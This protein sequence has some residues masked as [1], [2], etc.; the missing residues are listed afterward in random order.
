M[1]MIANIVGWIRGVWVR[2]FGLKTIE[3]V[4]SAEI[5]VSERMQN[6]ID[7]WARMYRNEPPWAKKS[8]KGLNLPAAISGEVARAVTLEMRVDCTGSA[9]AEY[10]TEQLDPVLREIRRIMEYAQAKGG[11]IIKPYVSGD[12]ILTDIIQ[13]D[14]FYPLAF[15]GESISD[16]I[17][18]DRRQIGR[19]FFTRLERHR[20]VA[21]GWEVSNKAFRSESESELGGETSLTAVPDWAELEPIATF[22]NVDFPLFAYFRTPYSN[23]IDPGSP[24]GVS[25]FA[26]AVDLIEDADT[27][28][29]NLLWEFESGKRALYADVLA[30][31]RD[32]N[33][34]PILPEKRL[35]RVLNESKR[36]VSDPVGFQEWTPTLREA[37]ILNGLDAILKRIEFTC[38]LA[39]GTL[40]NPET[41][42]KTAT[43]IA[44]TKQRTYATIVD[45][46][47]ALEFTL[48]SLIQAMDVYAT[49]YSL[50]PAGSYS[51][52]FDFD[53]STVTDRDAQ[54]QRDLRLVQAG[55]MSKTEFRVRNLHEDEATAKKMIADVEAQTPTD[56]F[57]GG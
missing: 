32:E 7:L 46:Q 12:T 52:A 55:I 47:K 41:V 24:L 57:Q 54:F 37:N 6:A 42:A 5:A 31:D 19:A 13:A 29:S 11:I 20:K 4:F 10:L 35:Y 34:N 49:I 18:A 43:E 53:D 45:S 38:G 50:A 15:E 23:N 33:G 17:F 30:F 40:S 56:L 21:D 14:A 2:M 9:R 27:Q 1:G 3:R 36:S 51:L 26:R 48:T 44:L 28:W 25:C 8:V 22:S 39:Y 16:V